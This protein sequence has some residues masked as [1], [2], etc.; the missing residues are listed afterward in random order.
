MFG[1]EAQKCE[2]IS[3]LTEGPAFVIGSYL[4]KGCLQDTWSRV[5]LLPKQQNANDLMSQSVEAINCSSCPLYH[6]KDVFC[7]LL[8]PSVLGIKVFGKLKVNDFSIHRNV[9]PVLFYGFCIIILHASL[10]FLLIF[11]NSHASTLARGI[12]VEAGPHRSGDL[13]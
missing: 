3:I 8:P 2:P 10:Y 1:V 11:L 4:R 12:F 13:G 6:V 7:C 5:A 9:L